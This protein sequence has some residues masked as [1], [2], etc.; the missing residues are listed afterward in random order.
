[1]IIELT[2]SKDFKIFKTQQLLW[3][4]SVTTNY[5]ILLFLRSFS[6]RDERKI[7]L[8]AKYS[9]ILASSESNCDANNLLRTKGDLRR[10]QINACAA[11]LQMLVKKTIVKRLWNIF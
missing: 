2:L 3:C 6:F 5:V 1:M 8:V 9:A 10:I 4:E 7:S 11:V